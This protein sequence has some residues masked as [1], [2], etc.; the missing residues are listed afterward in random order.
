[1]SH[2]TAHIL[3]LIINWYDRYTIQVMADDVRENL[4]IPFWQEQ[5]IEELIKKVPR[6]QSAMSIL[7]QNLKRGDEMLL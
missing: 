5:A 3:D 2:V 1:M 7:K 6:A 4:T